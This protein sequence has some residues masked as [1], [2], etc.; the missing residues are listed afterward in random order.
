MTNIDPRLLSTPKGGRPRKVWTDEECLQLLQTRNVMSTRQMAAAYGVSHATIC[1][2]L[3]ASREHFLKQ[4][5]HA[6]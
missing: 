3:K 4:Q 5:E 6:V 1:N 2:W